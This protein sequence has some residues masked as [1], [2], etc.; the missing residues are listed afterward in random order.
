MGASRISSDDHYV[1]FN[2][3]ASNLVTGDT[4]GFLD[5]FV[6]DRQNATTEKVSVSS[7]GEQAN[8]DRFNF[9]ISPDGRYVVFATLA[10][11]LVGGVIP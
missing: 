10:S 3:F 8:Y 2:S 4:G 7:S 11:N 9:E 5:I 1:A 6:R